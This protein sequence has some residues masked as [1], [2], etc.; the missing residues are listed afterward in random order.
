MH[1]QGP[2]PHAGSRNSA[3][4]GGNPA[5]V[6]AGN[7]ATTERTAH[8]SAG[9]ISPAVAGPMRQASVGIPAGGSAA[10]IFA[11]EYKT[12]V[13]SVGATLRELCYGER[14]LIVPVPLDLVPPAFHGAI[15][16]PWPNRIDA[17]RYEFAGQHYQAAINEPERNNA[18]HGLAC[19]LNWE[20]MEISGNYEL[21]GFVEPGGDRGATATPADT[22]PTGTPTNSAVANPAKSHMVW[23]AVVSAQE[24]YPSALELLA[25]FTLDAT[26]G[27]TWQV[28]ATN[29]GTKAVPYGIATHPYVRGGT[30]TV[31]DWKLELPASQVLETTP[32]RLLPRALHDVA[33]FAGGAFDFRAGKAL[34]G[35]K[36]DHAFTALFANGSETAAAALENSSKAKP[37]TPD[38]NAPAIASARIIDPHGQGCQVSWDVSALPWVQVFTADLGKPGFPDRTGIAIEAMTCPANA[39]NS[40]IGLVQLGPGSRHTATWN[41]VSFKG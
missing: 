39:F 10:T 29:I 7:S 12:T 6:D 40:K 1:I 41:I 19:W 27:L 30:G 16:A 25:T 36:I 35:S 32:D 38:R 33:S 26:S 37:G 5:V 24:A 4:G 18:S 31:D 13:G 21:R 8:D 34:G 14:D 17:G 9:F 3:S 23:R 22:S 2:T 15:L 28:T 20:L 11:G